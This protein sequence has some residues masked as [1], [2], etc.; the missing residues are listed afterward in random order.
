M[1]QLI[2][3][4]LI[5]QNEGGRQIERHVKRYNFQMALA[6]QLAENEYEKFDAHRKM[7]SSADVKQLENHVKSIAQEKKS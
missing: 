2:R 6:K 3:E 1:N 4:F 7:L 5:V